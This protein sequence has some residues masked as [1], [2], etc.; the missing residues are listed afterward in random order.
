MGFLFIIALGVLTYYVVRKV[1]RRSNEL[2]EPM[3]PDQ[4]DGYDS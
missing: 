2:N 4:S 3:P 1:K